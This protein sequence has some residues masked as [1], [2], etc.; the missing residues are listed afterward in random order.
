[1]ITNNVIDEIGALLKSEYNV[2]AI[3]GFP[4]PTATGIYLNEYNSIA[5]DR[6][7]NMIDIQLMVC[8][9]NPN[10]IIAFN[11]SKE[12]CKDVFKKIQVVA[13]VTYI[14]S[15]PLGYLNN[16]HDYAINFTT[17]ENK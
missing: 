5:G 1:M 10:K 7:G 6:E 15:V 3:I 4:S 14:N 12:Q 16:R 8:V 13:D 9:S 17:S 11:Q 2:N